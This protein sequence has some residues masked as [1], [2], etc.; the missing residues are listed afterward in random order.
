MVSE[1]PA[2]LVTCSAGRETHFSPA[3]PRVPRQDVHSWE[4]VRKEAYNIKGHYS[5]VIPA[6]CT[7]KE[8]YS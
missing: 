1:C 3:A 7:Q 5:D 4:E 2:T 6:D 8:G